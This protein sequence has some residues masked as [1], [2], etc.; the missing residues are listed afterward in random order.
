MINQR[1]SEHVQST[2]F[3]LTLSRRMIDALYFCKSFKCVLSESTRRSL[4]GRGLIHEVEE[5][6]WKGPRMVLKLTDAGEAVLP[7]LKLAGLERDYGPPAKEYEP[8][9]VK[10]TIK[11]DDK[12]GV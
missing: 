7:L 8:P 1:F 3:S 2:A 4:E 11:V 6:T 12:E 5:E 9:K 10:V